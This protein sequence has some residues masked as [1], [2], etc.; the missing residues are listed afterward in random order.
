MR[1]DSEPHFEGVSGHH[2]QPYSRGQ[3][4]TEI[5]VAVAFE[6]AFEVAFEGAFEAAFEAAFVAA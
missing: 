5:A 1:S 3:H 4:C 2:R 6:A